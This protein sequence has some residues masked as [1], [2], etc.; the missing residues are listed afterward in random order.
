MNEQRQDVGQLENA[1]KDILSTIETV[2]N[3]AES[4]LETFRPA[5]PSALAAINTFTGGDA[6]NNLE[7]AST[8]AR[9]SAYILKDEPVIARVVTEDEDGKRKTY[10]ICRTT[11]IS[12][13]GN[14]ASYKSAIGRLAS[15][16]AGSDFTLADGKSVEIIERFQLFPKRPTGEWDSIDTVAEWNS[17]VK[18]TLKSLR[19]VLREHFD[20]GAIDDLISQLLAQETAAA[21]VLEGTRRARITRM[22]LR[23]Q[24]IL[25]EFQDEIFRLPLGSSLLLVGPPGTGKTTTLIRR[26]GQKIWEEYLSVDERRAVQY[27]AV[28][29]NVHSRSWIMF[30]PTELLKLY[31]KEAFARE[32]IAASSFQLQTWDQYR[33]DVARNILPILRSNT[34]SGGIF[35][36]KP[37]SVI[38]REDTQSSCIKWFADF[39]EWQ[40]ANYV[41]QLSDAAEKLR[42]SD[43]KSAQAI[44]ADYLEVL[45]SFPERQLGALLLEMMAPSDKLTEFMVKLRQTTDDVIRKSLNGQYRGDP[46]LLRDLGHFLET[47]LAPQD[48]E[49]TEEL[50]IEAEDEEE[51]TTPRSAIES[52]VIAYGQ[53][54]RA[55]ARSFVL[56]RPLAKSSKNAR[57]IDWLRDRKAD[58]GDL[59]G[60]GR[61]LVLLQNARRIA[62]PVR[63]YFADLPK[64]YR[65]FR[66][67]RQTE[68]LWYAESFD[69]REIGPFE[70]DLVLLSILN[71]GQL[72]IHRDIINHHL[73]EP[74]W[75]S[76]KSVTSLWR[77]QVLVDEATDFSPIQLRCMASLCHPEIRSF[78]ACGDFNQRLTEWGTQNSDDIRWASPGVETRKVTVGYRQSRQLNLLAR[79]LIELR[80]EKAPEVVLPDYVDNDAVLPLLLENAKTIDGA[81]EWLTSCISL[82]EAEVGLM[83]SIAVFVNSEEEVEPC[84]TRLRLALESLNI[85]V[86]AAVRGEIIGQANDVRVFDIRHI[87]GLEFEAAFFIGID[88]LAE[89]KPT[90]IDKYMYVGVTRAATYLGIVSF[91]AIPKFLEPLRA[92]FGQTWQK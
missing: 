61:Q 88:K 41:A 67:Q 70:V 43:D 78:F 64:R 91:G 80:G 27:S 84:A 15:L 49:V 33:H 89:L 86:T 58:L 2:A 68:G 11:P 47:L 55:L 1:A 53:A 8:A 50:D 21:N 52:A 29:G 48:L 45:S 54:I 7:R 75:S 13:V 35:T 90:L 10:Y 23:D 12:A 76:V 79:S 24:P 26:L 51:A 16:G 72:A 19:A 44:A 40:H 6:V 59:E 92:Q 56:K 22:E 28:D 4:Q 63:R 17:G 87:K 34:G 30:T 62:Q 83:P 31:L 32:N 81:V 77:N 71:A 73:H 82:I 74:N 46:T 57:V 39:D 14:L 38:L 65:A 18:Q 85:N 9:D 25:D 60:I 5:G 37:E 3:Q 20:D 66:R 69:S 42:L 36:Y